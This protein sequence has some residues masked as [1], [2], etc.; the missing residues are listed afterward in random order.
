MKRV[1]PKDPERAM[2]AT[3]LPSTPGK[4]ARVSNPQAGSRGTDWSCGLGQAVKG[5]VA[6]QDHRALR[7][8]I[9]QR[10][11][12][13]AEKRMFQVDRKLCAVVGHIILAGKPAPPTK[14][15]SKMVHSTSFTEA[16]ALF[17]AK[18]C[19]W[20]R[21]TCMHACI[22]KHST[23]ENQMFHF[24]PNICMSVAL[25]NTL[26]FIL[27]FMLLTNTHTKTWNRI[28]SG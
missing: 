5:F 4:W 12:S 15:C 27:I 25:Q 20:D 9:L 3:V 18:Q 1:L 28:T 16:I 19:F 7:A 11:G 8:G 6:E 14:T 2:H 26:L 13:R 23:P 22:L 17:L 24:D 10:N 21:F